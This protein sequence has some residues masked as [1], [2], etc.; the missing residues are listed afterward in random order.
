V[1][2]SETKAPPSN[3]KFYLFVAAFLL[4]AVGV[5]VFSALRTGPT[6]LERYKAELRAKGEKLTLTELLPSAGQTNH[7]PLRTNDLARLAKTLATQNKQVEGLELMH[8]LGNGLAEPVWARTNL[9][10]LARR[11]SPGSTIDWSAL[12][13]DLAAV[14]PI[15]AEAELLVSVP[16]L[17]AGMR[18]GFKVDWPEYRGNKVV[19][20]RWFAA[21]HSRNM[22]VGNYPKASNALRAVINLGEWHREELTFFDQRRRVGLLTTALMLTWSTAQSRD[23]EEPQLAAMISYW[24]GAGMYTNM[25]RALSFE[26]AGGLSSFGIVRTNGINA[27]YGPMGDKLE[28]F[29]RFTRDRDELFYLTAFQTLIE[30][31]RLAGA[32]KSYATVKH[33]L[34]VGDEERE[35]NLRGWRGQRHSVSALLFAGEEF[36][37]DVRQFVRYEVFRE[38]TLA[39][40]ALELHRRKHGRH[41]ETL[42]RLVPEFLPAVPVDWMDGQPLRYRLNPDGSFTLWSVGDNL[43]DD[44]GDASGPPVNL[45]RNDLWEG[46]DAVWPTLPAKPTSPPAASPAQP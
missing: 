17:H 27:I 9:L 43:T 6:E 29:A 12:E 4:A 20:S 34:A 31:V 10:T 40:L 28:P 30:H 44:G 15:L 1:S 13:A 21:A 2:D 18:Y 45:R 5:G 42:S 46:R 33:D 8:H 41:P 7:P 24:R 14:E 38:L 36:E 3:R 16:D 26:R 11:G 23:V 19:V 25:T 39:A 22:R 35:R 37:S 32:T